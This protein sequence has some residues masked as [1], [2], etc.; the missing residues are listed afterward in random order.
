M[1]HQTGSKR[2]FVPFFG[3]CAAVFTGCAQQ[4]ELPQREP[5]TAKVSRPLEQTV[6]EYLEETGTTEAVGRVD[7]RARV[8]GFLEQV[9]FEAGVEV[10]KGDVL[11]VIEQRP[12]IAARK[13]AEATRD[14]QK[15]ELDRAEIEYQRELKL[16][17]RNATADTDVVTARAER[18][19]AVAAVAAA[20]AA[21]DQAKLD[22]EYT[23]VKA[24]ISGR[25]GKTLVKLGN[26]VEK[27][28]ATHLTTIVSY[29]PIY[30]NFNISERALLKLRERRRPG[31]DEIDKQQVKVL[32]GRAT[33]PGFPFEGHFDYA[34]LA[35]DQSTG[36]YA[37][38]GIF[39][40]ADLD[41]VPG[42]FV[43]IRVPIGQQEGAL[44]VPELAMGADQAGR[45]VLVVNSQDEVERRAVTV[46]SKYRSGDPQFG[47]M[48]VVE[49]GLQAADRV[50]I[51]GLQRAR[52]GGK[53]RPEPVELPAVVDEL[54]SARQQEVP[55]GPPAE[56]QPSPPRA[57]V[58][59]P[60]QPTP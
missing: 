59:A 5:P 35:V 33:D 36:T 28:A 27:T 49:E 6:T 7:V 40:N 57:A 25:V 60:D 50:I 54:E 10:R 22:E 2:A 3:I 42:L 18:D 13:A 29:D 15:V 52:P 55:A 8:T 4:A 47:D 48:V 31:A 39:P 17:E 46:G 20:E 16:K 12:F 26:L 9:N 53:V 44:L 34:D 37:I 21:L 32:L 24:P 19:A 43:R 38:R 41:I 58:P 14:A 51:V 1:P 11:Y 45:Y 30:A 56:A 23:E